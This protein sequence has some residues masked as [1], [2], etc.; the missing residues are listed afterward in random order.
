MNSEAIKEI[1]LKVNG[2][3]AEREL[4][5]IQQ[6]IVKARKEKEAFLKNAPDA[7]S[8]TKEQE[9]QWRELNATIGKGERQLKKWGN[10]ADQV[11]RVLDNLS[12]ASMKELKSN[13]K[14]LERLMDSGAIKRNTDDWKLLNE[15]IIKTKAE[16]THIK[17]ETNIEK[18]SNSIVKLGALTTIIRGIGDAAA[19][20]YSRAM[21]FV[22][23]FARMDEAEV[24]VIKYTGLARS[25]VES[26][27]ESFKKMETRTPR[28][29]L[30]ALA[31][32]A[33]RLGIQS[34]KDILDFVAAAD[35]LNVALGEDLGADGV[36]NI[37]KLAQLFGDDKKMGLKQAM[38]STGSVINE[39][40][41]SSSAA[42]G[43]LMD[44]AGRVAGVSNQAHMSQ[45]QIMGFASV[46]DQSMVGVERGATAFQNV[47]TALYKKPAE[48]ARAAGLDVKEFARTLQ[49]D[50]NAAFL[51][52]LEGL[53]RTGGIEKLAPILADLKLSGSGVTQT[54]AALT[55]NIDKLS[56][57]QS[58]A[59]KAFQEGTSVTNEFNQQN[60]SAQAKLEMSRK[61][62]EDLRIELGQALWPAMTKTNSVIAA[63]IQVLSSLIRFFSQN[64]IALTMLTTAVVG[65]TLAVKAQTLAEHARNAAMTI[66]KAVSIGYNVV[67]NLLRLGYGLMT[68]NIVMATTAQTALNA[69]MAANPIGAVIS[70]LVALVTIIGTA[71]A[72]MGLFTSSSD[73]STRALTAQQQ[74]QQ[75]LQDITS[76][77]NKSIGEQV[78][79][80]NTLTAV[81]HDNSRSLK[82]RRI[83]VKELQK[84]I[85]SYTAQISNEGRVMHE[86]TN[87][88]KNYIK[89]LRN[90]AI[91][92]GAKDKMAA[93]G[94]ELLDLTDSSSR[95]EN[96][97]R[98]RRNRISALKR[99]IP[100][101]SAA[102]DK[103]VAGGTVTS[104]DV[105]AFVEARKAGKYKDIGWDTW[106]KQKNVRQLAADIKQA[107]GWVEEAHNKVAKQNQRIDAIQSSLKRQG[108][109]PEDINKDSAP[110]TPK[111]TTHASTTP[112]TNSK[113]GK[114]GNKHKTKTTTKKVLTPDNSEIILESRQAKAELQKDF[115]EGRKDIQEYREEM[116]SIEIN[117]TEK[118]M[119][120]FVTSEQKKMDKYKA[121]GEKL[122]QLKQKQAEE[123]QAWSL[124]DL[125][126]QQ[127]Q[128]EEL[129]ESRYARG[130]VSEEAYN[131]QRNAITL[132]YLKKRAELHRQVG[133]TEEFEKAQQQ[134]QKESARQKLEQVKR[135]HDALKKYREEFSQKTPEEQYQN[136]LQLLTAAK[137]Q[138][139]KE[140]NGQLQE[141]LRV[142]EEFARIF[143]ALRRKYYD[144][145]G[146][147]DRSTQEILQRAGHQAS[148]AGSGGD[149]ADGVTNLF[150]Q[151]A[152]YQNTQQQLRAQL[153]D[154]LITR[155]QYADAEAEIERQKYERIASYATAA[156][157]SIGAMLQSVSQ[158]MQVNYENEAASVEER[159]NREIQAAGQSSARGKILEEKKQRDLARLKNKYNKRA[160]AIEISQAV[161]ST[162][163]AAINA[164]ASAS[165]VNWILG[166]IAA[167]MAVAAGAV[168]IAAITQQHRK[169][170]AGYFTGG[171][172]GGR[173]YRREAGVVHEGEFVANH[174]AVNNPHLLPMFQ[175]LDY[176]Q[177]HNTVASLTADDAR[178]VMPST[179][180]SQASVTVIDT[181]QPRTAEAIEQL[182]RHLEA[183]IQTYVTIDGPDGLARQWK[184]YKRLNR[185]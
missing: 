141:Q 8:W 109:N 45:A 48:M 37:G 77:A 125:E 167:A 144:K 49:T 140:A 25:E 70:A 38:L 164:Y 22:D 111:E 21:Q 64:S 114:K 15:A 50:G 106:L 12:G 62:V 154:G 83:A 185:E 96:A 118:Q 79:K 163:V 175:L 30:N 147:R 135:L 134:Y 146:I 183:P 71:V 9:K 184:H 113:K 59:A 92:Q 5:K 13:L 143:E 110:P 39:L 76:N 157:Q 93:L 179:A 24:Q 145:G 152:A 82:D 84:I 90:L 172:T 137:A 94:G 108:L 33:G 32:D 7:S 6:D 168:Q 60:S 75:D 138:A 14:S 57:T 133:N 120:L 139:L 169:Q 142:E 61:R 115:A 40:A 4:K 153:D 174:E 180:G 155:Q 3:Y 89:E 131:L 178:R 1:V 27:N 41:Q 130:L 102:I 150:S 87:A 54:I 104:Q 129:L 16:I 116:L 162:A 28:E 171:F 42:E 95:R 165:K 123:Q 34:K 2:D 26:L 88:V 74:A 151:I 68:G 121:L 117:A 100:E 173:N 80:V 19:G 122:I 47:L 124:R 127:S 11:K 55:Q 97:L 18:E 128:E 166:P 23:A 78:S 161:A 44:F 119:A 103:I 29:Q 170:S 181:A 101:L 46:L 36:K 72:A 51:Q 65:Y 73:K 126:R 107:E 176:A 105:Q 148:H 20:A 69:A 136:E 182:N 10:S 17:E 158:L 63:G 52:F 66:G 43:Y 98:I 56:A 67:L 149:M 159:Y 177:R 160:M 31:A 53:N 112:T 85:P 58:Q 99:E 81:I 91:L 132:K 35:Q 86:N 156:Y